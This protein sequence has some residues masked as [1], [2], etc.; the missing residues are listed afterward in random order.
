[1]EK[2]GI[3]NRGAGNAEAR[4]DRGAELE[5]L[6]GQ[7]ERAAPQGSALDRQGEAPQATCTRWLY[8]VP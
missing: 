2:V 1:M 6:I 8:C 4:A 5:R 7:M 3:R